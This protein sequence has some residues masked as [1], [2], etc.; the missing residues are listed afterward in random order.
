MSKIKI[1]WLEVVI[2]AFG[3]VWGF[4]EI[5]AEQPFDGVLSIWMALII[6]WGAKS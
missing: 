4:I 6:L 3:M 5:A 1:R 2:A